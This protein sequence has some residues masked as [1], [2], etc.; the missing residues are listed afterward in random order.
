[1]RLPRWGTLFTYGNA[2]VINML[3]RQGSGGIVRRRC[4]SS[5]IF[6]MS[7]RIYSMLRKYVTK[8]AFARKELAGSAGCCYRFKGLVQERLYLGCAWL[9]MSENPRGSSNPTRELT[10]SDLDKINSS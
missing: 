6:C 10:L 2:L 3:R 1:M 9:A 4:D 7:Y 8:I 5:V